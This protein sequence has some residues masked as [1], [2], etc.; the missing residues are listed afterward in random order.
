MATYCYYHLQA[1][2]GDL[3]I[4]E[5]TLPTQLE[6]ERAYAEFQQNWDDACKAG[7]PKLLRVLWKTF[8][9]VGCGPSAS[10]IAT[11]MYS[12]LQQLFPQVNF[13][14]DP[15]VVYTVWVRSPS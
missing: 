12:L 1:R 3:D 9:K 13:V 11:G 5:L 14:L 8:G 2:K 6:S 4:G 7:N 10:S 15:V